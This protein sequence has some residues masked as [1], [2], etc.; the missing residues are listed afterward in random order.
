MPSTQSFAQEL[1]A[2]I[3]KHLESGADPQDIVDELT[4]ESNLVFARYNLELYIAA[5]PAAKD[6]E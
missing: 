4:R 5:R 1:N 6:E 3:T 2:L